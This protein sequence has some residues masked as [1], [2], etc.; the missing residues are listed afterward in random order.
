MVWKPFRF[1]RRN[2]WTPRR[3]NL[4]RNKKPGNSGFFNACRSAQSLISGFS[5]GSLGGP[6]SAHFFRISQ[7]WP[8]DLDA[9]ALLNPSSI[10]ISNHFAEDPQRTALQI[11]LRKFSINTGRHQRRTHRRTFGNTG[12]TQNLTINRRIHHFDFD[13]RLN[14]ASA[15]RAG[16]TRPPAYWPPD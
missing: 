15:W 2:R 8:I 16:R 13:H 3:N 7:Q 12:Y 10:R 5:L 1:Q 9:I 4:R 14:H 11:Q 6:Q